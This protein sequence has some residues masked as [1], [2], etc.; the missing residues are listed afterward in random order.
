MEMASG[1]IWCTSRGGGGAAVEMAAPGLGG[2]G[3]GS[4][5]HG[6][7]GDGCGGGRG[8]RGRGGGGRGGSGGLHALHAL[9]WHQLHWKSS[10]SPHQSSQVATEESPADAWPRLHDSPTC[11][12][13][14]RVAS[15]QTRRRHEWARSVP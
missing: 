11:V 4:G 1:C 14:T 12:L 15:A 8:G 3:D 7:G 13:D 9:Q 10:R 5:A 2:G 6:G